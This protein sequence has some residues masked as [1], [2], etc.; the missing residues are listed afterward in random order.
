MKT[1]LRTLKRL[2]TTF[3]LLCFALLSAPVL[4]PVTPRYADSFS[5][6]GESRRPVRAAR[7]MVAST[8]RITSEIGVEI[9]RRGGNAIDAAI[10]V[11]FA[12]AVTY[13]EAGNIG[14]GGFMLIRLKDGRTTAIDYREMAPGAAT[15]T[16]YQTPTGELIRG[17]GSSTVGYRASGVPGTVAG[18]EMALRRYGSG[19]LTWAQLIEPA[20]LLAAQGFPVSYELARSFVNHRERLEGYIESRRIFLRNGNPYREN[21][22]L[23]QPELAATLARL[24]RFGARE[25]YTG[26]TARLI[27]ADMQRNRGLI[28]L[29][30]LRRYEAKEREPV[31]GTYRGNQI[32]SMSPP[33][34]GGIA[35]LQMLNILEG[36]DMRQMG[37]SSSERYHVTAEVM[38]RAFAD[39]AEY[40]GDP[41]FVRVPI[42]GL[43]DKAYAERLRAGINLERATPS[44]QV[45]AGRPAGAEPTETTHYSVIDAEGNVVSNTYTINDLYGSGVTIRGAGI[46]MNDEMDDFT[47]RPGTPNLFGLIQGER[48]AIEPRK[49]P[50]SSMTPTIVLREDSSFWFAV[51]ARGGPRIINTVFQIVTNIIDYDMTMQQAI[52]AP[53][54][55]HQWM[56]DE[57]LYEPY[58]LSTDT[59]RALEARGHRLTNRP[60]RIASA[61]GIMVEAET[62][63]RLGASDPRTG[64]VPVGY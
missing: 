24:Q 29:E 8:D 35:L 55:H 25:F 50:L 1:M 31:R 38:R 4:P 12:L 26:E 33:S 61:E 15:R 53:R 54:I 18:M 51:G 11:G 57:L 19:R 56:P 42:A 7:G 10:A 59:I 2:S 32:I 52:D 46:V 34:S 63:V 6:R 45:R 47:S 22:I 41:D 60:I 37:W 16:M 20:R 5:A 62:G 44:A 39:R 9:M 28:T 48:N 21:E 40:M 13:P 27:A 49:R 3:F 14:G 58:G 17:E 23:R 64:G 30:D 36:Y 43:I